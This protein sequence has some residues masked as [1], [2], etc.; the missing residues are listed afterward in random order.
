MTVEANVRAVAAGHSA[1]RYCRQPFGMPDDGT[2]SLINDWSTIIVEGLTRFESLL[3]RSACSVLDEAG[4]APSHKQLLFVVSTTKADIELMDTMGPDGEKLSPATAAMHVADRMGLA[5]RPIV[6]C[7]ACISGVSALV[8]ADRMLRT[9][10]YHYALVCGADVQSLFTLSGFQALKALDARP[11]RPFDIERLGLNLGEAAASMLL[12]RTRPS[13]EAEPMWHLL[14]GAVCNDAYHISTPSP[15]AE[16]ATRALTAVTEQLKGSEIALIN[17][18]G[19]GTLFN[20]QMESVAISRAGLSEIPVGTLKGYFGHTMGAAGLLETII[21]MAA[22]DGGFIPASRGFG[23]LGVSKPVNISAQNRRCKGNTFVKMISGFGGCNGVVAWEKAAARADNSLSLDKVA[24]THT[25]HVT[26]HRVEV[27]G[28]PLDTAS[29]G[30][31]MLTELYRCHIHDY[32]KYYKMDPLCRLGFVA[33]EL[34]L[35]AEKEGMHQSVTDH[36][37]RAVILFN[38]SSSIMADAAYHQSIC[39]AEDYYPSPAAFVYTLP[40]IVTGEIAIRNGY[41]GDTEFFILPEKNPAVMQQV[42][43]ATLCGSGTTT[44]ICGW[45]DYASATTFEAEINLVQT[46]KRE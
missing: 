28:K 45:L 37:S 24:V 31:D 5:N 43:Q 16:G 36:S 41:H 40:N 15:T 7:N 1:L 12:S 42:V 35:K 44:A 10:A 26:P 9:G 8:L 4:I 38:N 11:C 29:T 46:I 3:Y 17:T 25:V 39:K 23:E 27:D 14:A 33:T 30:A 20:D 6:V 18:H 22:L 2:V 13:E 21:T 19:T 34:L 32:P